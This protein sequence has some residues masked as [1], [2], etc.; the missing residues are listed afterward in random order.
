M[1]EQNMSAFKKLFGGLGSRKKE[2][3]ST[4]PPEETAPQP[5]A[6]PPAPPKEE[7]DAFA[8]PA[9]NALAKVWSRCAHPG[10]PV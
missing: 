2:A 8:V 6:A 7:P 10:R 5:D 4:L 3:E 9:G 1:P